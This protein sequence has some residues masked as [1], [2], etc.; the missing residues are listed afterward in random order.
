MADEKLSYTINADAAGN[1][2]SQVDLVLSYDPNSADGNGYVTVTAASGTYKTLDA[3]GAVIDSDTVT[4]LG[5]IGSGYGLPDNKLF[6]GTGSPFVTSDGITFTINNALDSNNGSGAVNYSTADG[7]D[8]YEDG[9]NTNPAST[10][11]ESAVV[12]FASGTFIRTASGEVAVEHLRVGDLVVSKSGAHHR[13]RWLGHRHIDCRRHP[14]RQE[15]SPVRIAA[16]A[17][18]EN[19]P[20]RDLFVSPGHSLCVDVVGEVL[21]PAMAL[22]NGST[23]AQVDVESVCYWHVELDTHEIIFA[24]NMPTESYLEMGNRSFF[25]EASLVSLDGSPDARVPTH[26]DFCRPFHGEGALVEAVRAQ[27]TARAERL[28]W[29]L[30]AAGS[31][32]PYLEVDGVRCEPQVEGHTLSFVLPAGA[33]DVWL[34]SRS[35]V[36]ATLMAST[37]GRSLGLCLYTLAV[38]CGSAAPRSLGIDDPRFCDGF[39]ALEREGARQW[40]WTNGRARLPSALW[41]GLETDLIV[42]VGLA[43]PA[44]PRWVA[45]AD[46]DAADIAAALVA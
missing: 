31:D 15:V 22:I 17:F 39:H 35:S 20:A 34:V 10:V 9:S 7:T 25:A 41:N 23:V 27:L 14:R 11:A 36:P 12:C 18:A 38:D 26:A 29:R 32:E 43:G 37:D 45:P 46:V 24:E 28:G 13:I 33:R 30:D 1:S 6:V 8:Y 42:R 44:L 2:G 5:A 16:H 4:G 3:K 19:R 40:R 21:I